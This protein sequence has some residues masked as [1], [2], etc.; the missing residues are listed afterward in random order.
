[1][2]HELD[3]YFSIFLGGG[4]L[5]LDQLLFDGASP[6]DIITAKEDQQSNFEAT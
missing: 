5:R 6:E 3:M 4:V 2:M 1:M